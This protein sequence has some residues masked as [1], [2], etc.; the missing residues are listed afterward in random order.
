MSFYNNAEQ[1]G[2]PGL[3]M[4]LVVFGKDNIRADDARP[5]VRLIERLNYRALRTAWLAGFDSATWRQAMFACVEDLDSALKSAEVTLTQR[6]TS[7]STLLARRLSERDENPADGSEVAFDN[8]DLPDVLER[9]QMLETLL[10]PA[11]QALTTFSSEATEAFGPE[12]GSLS[13]NQMR[14]RLFGAASRL[15]GPS[16]DVFE[17][18]ERLQVAV[19]EADAVLR[20][21]VEQMQAVR[22]PEVRQQLASMLT[23]FHDESGELEEVVYMV[24]QMTEMLKLVSLMNVALRNTLRPGIRGLQSIKSAMS[25]VQS[26]ERLS[27]TPGTLELE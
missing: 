10:N 15:K 16:E 19:E 18:C 1:L 26:W 8:E 27:V 6:E 20:G 24:D 14:A 21:L 23:S 3:I 11:V 9:F 25:T 4:P 22:L 17:H 5:E 2:V 12:L 7:T 13:P